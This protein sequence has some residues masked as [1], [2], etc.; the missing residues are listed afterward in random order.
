MDPMPKRLTVVG[1]HE[2]PDHYHLP[3]SA[4]CYFWGEY[5]PYEQTGGKLW[6]YSATNQLISNF[7]KKMDRQG[8]AEWRYK[9]QAIDQV[10]RSFAQFWKWPDIHQSHRVALVPVPPSKARSDPMYDPRMVEVVNGIAQHC[11]VPLDIRDC[12]TFS[13]KYAAS[14]EA[15][16]RPTPDEL[17][18]ELSFDLAVGRPALQPGVIFLFDDMLTTG[19]H[20]V[21]AANLLAKHFPGVPVVG[22]FVARR[23]VPNPFDDFDDLT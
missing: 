3:A 10:A 13:G 23:V 11:K 2:R 19:A 21:A 20:Y 8:H 22:N 6:N 5:T 4:R 1:D 9:R 18:A 7:K 12:L 17:L 16:S 15:D 14:H